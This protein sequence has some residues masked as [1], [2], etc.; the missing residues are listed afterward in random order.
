M[1]EGDF[2]IEAGFTGERLFV[3]DGERT[4]AEPDCAD[5]GA[6]A[7]DGDGAGASAGVF[8]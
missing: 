3:I 2:T 6:S 1:N 4:S 8:C 5:T 7:G